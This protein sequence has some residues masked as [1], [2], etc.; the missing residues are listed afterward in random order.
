VRFSQ[1]LAVIF[2][3]TAIALA[4]AGLELAA[5]VVAAGV[6]TVALLSAATGLCV[7][8]EVY[9]LALALRRGDDADVRP[10]LGLE[11]EGPWL[12]VLTAPGCARC[13]PVAR[14]VEQAAGG[15]T[16]VRVD[17]R[18]RPQAAVVPVK[19]VPALIVVDAGGRVR[20]A[21]A[22]ALER[23]EIANVLERLPGPAPA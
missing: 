11:G 14:A 9:R 12:V 6:A 8:C 1:W 19:S 20:E 10:A 15:R 21:R 5:W 7:G 13:G 23:A 18:E 3:S 2:L 16:V 17:L 22:G 4:L